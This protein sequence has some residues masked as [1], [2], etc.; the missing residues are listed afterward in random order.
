MKINL[1]DKSLYKLKG[2]EDYRKW[3]KDV[4]M[5]VTSI[6]ASY[7]LKWYG[8][9]P[10]TQP[11]SSSSTN[12]STDQS[13]K[14]DHITREKYK[15]ESEQVVAKLYAFLSPVYQDVVFKIAPENKNIPFVFSELDKM[16]MGKDVMLA[17][18]KKRDIDSFTFRVDDNFLSQL[19]KF[20]EIK[21][22]IEELGGQMSDQ[23]LGLIFLDALPYIYKDKLSVILR[24]KGEDQIDYMKFSF[25]KSEVIKIYTQDKAW[26]MLPSQRGDT[27]GSLDKAL[28]G[29]ENK[30]PHRPAHPHNNREG[31]G[32]DKG[33]EKEKKSDKRGKEGEENKRDSTKV[34][35]F[36]C[37]KQGHSMTQCRA[38]I[39]PE[40]QARLDAWLE[41]N[42]KRRKGKGNKEEKGKGHSRQERHHTSLAISAV[43]APCHEAIYSPHTF[44][45]DTSPHSHTPPTPLPPYLLYLMEVV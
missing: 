7:L 30:P 10:L 1:D 39:T 42:K 3:K 5:A 25:L 31:K 6:G 23:E 44:L 15:L 34:V 17:L 19:V 36:N 13:H 18:A 28:Y 12:I 20:E 11:P 45:P 27:G 43:P 24:A 29:Y 35:C 22:Q 16:L 41:K 9:H 33:K 21:L 2:A 32:K 38:P 37:Q 14:D 26:K 8:S 4:I 40:E